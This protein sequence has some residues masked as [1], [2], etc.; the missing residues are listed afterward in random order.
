M[1]SHFF[2]FTIQ[3]QKENKK[4]LFPSIIY[5]AIFYTLNYFNILKIGKNMPI[6][7]L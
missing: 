6:K 7:T 5:N 3:Y 2:F 1:P 4:I